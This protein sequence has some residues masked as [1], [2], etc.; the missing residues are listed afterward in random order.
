LKSELRRVNSFKIPC[1]HDVY[2]GLT[3][4]KRLRHKKKDISRMSYTEL[5]HAQTF[6]FQDVYNIKSM[7]GNITLT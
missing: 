3:S 4:I 5:G 2:D 1:H 7:Q 6:T